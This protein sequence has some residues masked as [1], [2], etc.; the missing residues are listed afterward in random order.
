[1]K[2]ELFLFWFVFIILIGLWFV[3]IVTPL[4]IDGYVYFLL[5]GVVTIG[6]VAFIMTKR[7]TKH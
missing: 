7:F 5:I 6:I 1:M 2:K 3:G 4:G